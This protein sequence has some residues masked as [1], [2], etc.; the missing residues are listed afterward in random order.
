MSEFKFRI[1]SLEYQNLQDR[2][3]GPIQVSSQ[4]LIYSLIWKENLTFLAAFFNRSD[5]FLKLKSNRQRFGRIGF[6][7]KSLMFFQ[8]SNPN[9][10]SSRNT[11][12]CTL[13]VS[14]CYRMFLLTWQLMSLYLEYPERTSVQDGERAVCGCIQGTSFGGRLISNIHYILSVPKSTENLYRFVINFGTLRR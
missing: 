14:T 11:V 3:S 2:L 10:S 7:F 1:N 8:M 5:N 6:I 9:F 13:H 4:V 12:L